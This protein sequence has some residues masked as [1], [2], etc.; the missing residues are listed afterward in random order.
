MWA[1]SDAHLADHGQDRPLGRIADRAIRLVRRSRQSGADQDR[2]DQ[3]ARPAGELLGRAADQLGEDHTGVSPRAQK[4]CPRNRGDDLVPPD[5]VD[6]RLLRGVREP[7]ELMQHRAQGEDHVVARVAVGDREHVQVIDLFAPRLERGKSG[8]DD[9]AE[10]NYRS[11][12]QRPGQ[13]LRVGGGT[14]L[15]RLNHLASL[16]A[17]GADV[18]AAGRPGVHDPDALEI[19]IEPPLRGH[20]RV[21]TTVA[22]RGS[23]PARVT[24]LGHLRRV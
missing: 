15:R 24:D 9:R 18:D 16:Q 11:V 1:S 22:E 21:A 13:R 5:A 3:L 23:F 6:R 7:V 19:G 4:R 14:P 20:H 17:A 12:G 8:L 10:A 2:V